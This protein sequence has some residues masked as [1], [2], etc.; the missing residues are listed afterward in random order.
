MTDNDFNIKL[1]FGGG[2][3][4]ATVLTTWRQNNSTSTYEIIVQGKRIA[5]LEMLDLL[6]ITTFG[7]LDNETVNY[8]GSQIDW[9]YQNPK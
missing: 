9:Y 8:I 6:W 2:L 5:Q 4:D 1:N 7:N 3:I